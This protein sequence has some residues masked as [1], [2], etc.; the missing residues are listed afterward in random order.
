DADLAKKIVKLIK[1][2][3]LKVQASIQGDTVRV[4]GAK[5][6]VLQDAIAH[7]KKSVTDF[8]LKFGNFRD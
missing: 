1:D 8:P 7:V 5:R 2:S 4:N 3:G 6:D